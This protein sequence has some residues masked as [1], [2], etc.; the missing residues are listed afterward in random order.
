MS[1]KPQPPL[2][3]KNDLQKAM[4]T[5]DAGFQHEL[6]KAQTPRKVAETIAVREHTHGPFRQNAGTAQALKS[7]CRSPTLDAVQMEA[8]EMICTKIARIVSGDAN[9]KD[10][11]VDIAGYAALVAED[12]KQ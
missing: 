6:N 5:V 2:P 8:L 3:P 12:I 9:T 10:H 11:W 1:D 4:D 7:I